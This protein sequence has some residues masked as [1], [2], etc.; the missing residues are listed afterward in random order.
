MRNFAFKGIDPYIL[1]VYANNVA[2]III[3]GG[4]S[5]NVQM[6]RS[7]FDFYEMKDEK[8]VSIRQLFAEFGK[9]VFL[10]DVDNEGSDVGDLMSQDNYWDIFGR[11]QGLCVAY[12]QSDEGI[13]TKSLNIG[14]SVLFRM[15]VFNNIFDGFTMNDK[16]VVNAL[17]RLVVPTKKSIKANKSRNFYADLL[18]GDDK[19]K[20][21]VY[22]GPKIDI[23][24]TD[25]NGLSITFTNSTAINVN[26]VLYIPLAFLYIIDDIFNAIL[27][28]GTLVNCDVSKLPKEEAS[29]IEPVLK[30][31]DACFTDSGQKRFIAV[32]VYTLKEK[33]NIISELIDGRA[34]DNW[35]SRPLYN[36]QRTIS[37]S[38]ATIRTVYGKKEKDNSIKDSVYSLNKIKA[39]RGKLGLLLGDFDLHFYN[40]RADLNST[41]TIVIDPINLAFLRLS[42]REELVENARG[43]CETANISGIAMLSV[44][45]EFI[46]YIFANRFDNLSKLW[47]L[48]S[49]PESLLNANDL[50]SENHYNFMINAAKFYEPID[51]YRIAKEPELAFIFNNS[52]NKLGTF[53]KRCVKRTKE[54]GI[55]KNEYEQVDLPVVDNTMSESVVHMVRTRRREI[56]RNTLNNNVCV[57]S[58]KIKKYNKVQTVY[59]TS[60]KS[61]IK[62]VYGDDYIGKYSALRYRLKYVYDKLGSLG[63]IADIK[64]LLEVTALDDLAGTPMK[65]GVNKDGT[66]KTVLYDELV[67]S[68]DVDVFKNNVYAFI[69]S[70][71]TKAGIKSFEDAAESTKDAVD[72]P[73]PVVNLGVSKRSAADSKD[74][75]AKFNVWVYEYAVEDI[76]IIK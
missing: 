50:Y 1:S 49:V 26:N 60:N 69:M 72:R 16:K 23:L 21:H 36:Y 62:A 74:G 2:S 29:I 3:S 56:I 41:N 31:I 63:N 17:N 4:F 73:I 65:V 48:T 7:L 34:L 68:N 24:D 13:I 67:Y 27:D 11:L 51:L 53:K 10:N 59:V 55:V 57:V 22:C 12:T 70:V 54:L 61:V 15:L 45:L 44:Y 5:D 39:S 43:I 25:D 6:R 42:K 58:I 32:N 75:K 46:D 14:S 8:G 71:A 9:K 19:T 20:E 38:D 40:L 64:K 35:A 47:E 28:G 18:L 76:K 37:L 52:K 66:S 30:E 33:K